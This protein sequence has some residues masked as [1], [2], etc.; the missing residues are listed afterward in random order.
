MTTA[1][2]NRVHGES[3]ERWQRALSRAITSGLEVFTVADTG[4]RMVTSASRLDILHR[5]DGIACTCEAALGG[6][7]VCQHRAAVRYCLGWLLIEETQLGSTCPSCSGGGVLVYRSGDQEPCPDC[8]GS[9]VRIDRWLTG[10]PS[11]EII[12]QAA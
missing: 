1:V 11:V 4:E 10:G 5:T 12:A 7:A 3:A 2:V 8:G 9:G 6:D